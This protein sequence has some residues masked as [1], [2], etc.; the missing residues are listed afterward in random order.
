MS[1]REP[2]SDPGS[3]F[4]K[5]L[6][7]FADMSAHSSDSRQPLIT[8]SAG[9]D[10]TAWVRCVG[11]VICTHICPN[12]R[13]GDELGPGKRFQ[14]RVEAFESAIKDSVAGRLWHFSKW[15]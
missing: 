6:Q 2:R 13:M 5:L 7:E 15:I 12:V 8:D 1:G 10:R 3:R 11:S 9:L 4:R 14:H